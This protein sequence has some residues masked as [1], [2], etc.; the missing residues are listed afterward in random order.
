MSRSKPEL[1][2]YRPGSGRLRKS[3]EFSQEQSEPRDRDYQ[4]Q[5]QLVQRIQNL[6]FNEFRGSTNSLNEKRNYRRSDRDTYSTRRK[7]IFRNIGQ[8][9]PFKFNQS[10]N[11]R[12]NLTPFY[13]ISCLWNLGLVF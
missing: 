5:D 11:P 10:T 3:G 9:E 4:E 2:L 6:E 1:E 13:K 12:I 8:L 7:Y